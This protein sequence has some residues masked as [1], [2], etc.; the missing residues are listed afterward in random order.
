M[1][2]KLWSRLSVRWENLGESFLEV[3]AKLK[4]IAWLIILRKRTMKSDVWKRG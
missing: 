3:W 2:Q 1:Q 4:E